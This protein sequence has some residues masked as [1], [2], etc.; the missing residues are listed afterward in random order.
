MPLWK[1]YHPEHAFSIEDKHAIA[2]RIT[3][4]Y[5]D[6][7]PFYVGV[8]FEAVAK[9]SYYIGG[10]PADD[11]VRISVDHIARQM[12]DDETKQ[13]FLGAVTKLLTPYL[14]ERGLRWEMHVDETPF[15]L[16]TIGGVR[17]PLPG[18]DDEIRWRSENRPSP[19]SA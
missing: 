7:P 11:F 1:V 12:K 19:T 5:R 14:S 9:S 16:W 13:R 6:L 2:Q 18:T 17:P 4:I 15:S 8:V 10:E 3:G